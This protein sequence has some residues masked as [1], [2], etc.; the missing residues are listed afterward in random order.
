MLDASGKAIASGKAVAPTTGAYGPITLTGTGPFRVEACGSVSGRAQCLWGATSN[1]G[2]LNLTPLTSAITVLAGG[3]PPAA[4]MTGPVQGLAD[5]DLAAA[6]TQLRNALAPALADAGLASGFDLLTGALTPGSHTGYDRLL[7][8]VS[9]SLGVDSKAYVSL[10]TQF[11][12]GTAYLEPGTTQGSLSVNAGSATVDFA[13]IDSLFQ[14]LGG[15]MPNTANCTPGLPALLDANARSSISPVIAAFVGPAQAKDPLCT[16]MLG[17]L[18]GDIEPLTGSTLLPPV[19]RHCDFSASDPV[20]RV[21][22]VFQT[23]KGLQRQVGIE[24]A[25]VKR[26]DGWKLLGNR[27][28]VQASATARLVLARRIDQTAAD[29]FTRWLDIGI[30][31]YPGLA[32]ARV[33]QKDGSG[34][35]VALALFKPA[36]S[37]GLLSLWSVGGGSSAVSLDPAS[38]TVRS[39]NPTSLDLPGGAAGDATARNFVRAGRA[40]KVEL[41]S[42]AACSTALAGA[43]GGTVSVDVNGMLPISVAGMSAQPW[44]VLAAASNTALI[45]LKGAANAKLSFAPTWASS[46]GGLTANRAQLCADAACGLQLAQLELTGS[47][48]TAALS[49]T[50]SLLP[51]GASDYKLL[52]ITGRTT[53]GLVLQLDTQSCASQAAA[54][55]C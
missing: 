39:I 30:P 53:D 21:N 41:F 27:L 35:D 1:G 10:G 55:P 47:A 8:T 32:C 25:V 16:H 52:R 28:E 3:Q 50:L 4:L 6:Q 20:C 36:G 48:T 31:A 22:L 38:G 26:A 18:D 34:A 7:D 19:P 43:D 42:D 12:S 29:T 9:V 2:T 5:S 24:Q 49:A 51:L 46:P 17:L 11:G 37:N 40:L 23:A 45:A 44:P 33:S 14:A 15:V 54:L 13:G